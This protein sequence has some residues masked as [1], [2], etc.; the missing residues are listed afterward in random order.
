MTPVGNALDDIRTNLGRA[1]SRAADFRGDVMQ[2]L[3]LAESTIEALQEAHDLAKQV[4]IDMAALLVSA[5][6]EV[7]ASWHAW[8]VVDHDLEHG[9]ITP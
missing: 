8:R 3:R 7:P 9:T 6:L 2:A 5:D 1:H 4:I